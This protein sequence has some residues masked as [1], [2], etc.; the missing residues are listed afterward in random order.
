[1]PSEKILVVDDTSANLNLLIET[2][3]PRGYEV[4]AAQSGPTAIKLA[5]RA[6]P[7]LILL[8]ILMPG[9]DGLETC[10]QL[11][12]D[13]ATREVPVIFITAKSETAS[14][15]SG[16]T[17]GAVDYITKPFQ[18]D[19]VL[20]RV[21]THLQISR[22]TRELRAK[23]T[24]L[25]TEIALRR[26]AEQAR[27]RAD[28]R[29]QSFSTLEAER[30]G[31]AGFIGESATVHQILQNVRR[32]HQFASTS[33]LIT[34]ESGTG[35][36][37]IARAIH[38]GSTRAAEPFVA[39]NCVAV[40][41]DLAESMFFGHTKGSF[42]G[43]LADRKGC[44][45]LADGGTLF[46]DEIGDM[47]AQLQ[48]KLLRVLEDGMIT[49]VG[50]SQAKKVDVRII[51]ATNAD[52]D[53]QI[54]SGVFRQDLYFR[55]ARY[56]VQTPPLRERPEDIPLLASHFVKI[57]SAEMGLIP[58]TLRTDA[59]AALQAY[60]FPGNVREMKN[61]IERALI[62]SA[63]D[64]IAANHLHLRKSAITI[65]TAKMPK[66]VPS[67]VPLGADT[68]PLADI[69]LNLEQAEEA[70]IQRALA[71]TNGNVTE[72]ARLLGINRTRIYRRMANESEA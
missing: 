58:P 53:A 32:L 45:E 37:L 67:S 50:A 44:F 72:A 27:D 18:Q 69:P 55:L 42:T 52:L 38:Y 8:D 35:K 60:S 13:P 71:Q 21:H 30:W 11:K 14:L 41:G 2:L 62:E 4:L 49:P 57:L 25:E 56:I 6:R 15:V 61:L 48:A 40:P 9:Q 3:K 64:P 29:L 36:E 47:P 70:L 31:I 59:L 16:F 39:V 20:S 54:A 26:R 10:Q 43:A 23:N 1:M 66:P 65:P 33:V 5:Q 68:P 63:G 24:E 34:G 28:A 12:R 51:A 17:A 46:L 19:E 7:D 22:L